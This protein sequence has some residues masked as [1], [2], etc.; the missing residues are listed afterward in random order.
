[1]KHIVPGM[2]NAPPLASND[3][4]LNEVEGEKWNVQERRDRSMMARNFGFWLR[5]TVSASSF[6]SRLIKQ[7]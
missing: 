1:M 4:K 3:E 5:I 6:G 7:P 2:R